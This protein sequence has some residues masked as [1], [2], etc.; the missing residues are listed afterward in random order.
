M[1][2]RQLKSR[3]KLR[4]AILTLAASRQGDEITASEVAALAGVNRSTFY[5][6]AASPS[7]LLELVLRTELDE[8]RERHLRHATAETA[9]TAMAEVT[10]AVLH[11]V[12]EHAL[13]YALGLNE[14]SGSA[15][16]HPMLSSHFGASIRLLVSLQAV[17]IEDHD[18]AEAHPG[19]GGAAIE[20]AGSIRA[21]QTSPIL[22]TEMATRFIADGS[23]GAIAT[24]LDTPEPRDAEAFLHA[25]RQL[26]PAWWPL[27]A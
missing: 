8:I 21:E 26:L 4:T 11:H 5:E 9:G 6:H 7:A 15:S 19:H 23:V 12:D 14:T 17:T 25:Y 27:S 3:E 20:R 1:D 10:R 2:A 13:I 18:I 24:W 16:L 22:L